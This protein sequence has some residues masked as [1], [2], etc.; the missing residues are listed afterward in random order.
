ML[1][2]AFIPCLSLPFF[3][4][5]VPLFIHFLWFVVNKCFKPYCC[6]CA[7][8]FM[9]FDP[10]LCF[11][12]LMWLGLIKEQVFWPCN[13]WGNV[14]FYNDVSH[15][16]V[17]GVFHFYLGLDCRLEFCKE[18]L[19]QRLHNSL[20]LPPCSGFLHKNSTPSGTSHRVSGFR[21]L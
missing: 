18:L 7:F 3:S 20:P 13:V 17:V 16:D 14:F 21:T 8:C 11:V 4:T 1:H 6:C 2:F 10:S 5:N 12:Y 15:W 19:C 9:N